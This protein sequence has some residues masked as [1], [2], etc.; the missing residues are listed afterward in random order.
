MRLALA[1]FQLGYL[2]CGAFELVFVASCLLPGCLNSTFYPEGRHDQK[3]NIMT[4][5][6]ILEEQ[7][8]GHASTYWGLFFTMRPRKITPGHLQSRRGFCVYFAFEMVLSGR[9]AFATKMTVR[10]HKVSTPQEHDGERYYQGSGGPLRL[11][12]F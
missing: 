8:P 6:P 4:S 1:R 12:R 9:L 3:Q 10:T 2:V 11:R 5:T 7:A